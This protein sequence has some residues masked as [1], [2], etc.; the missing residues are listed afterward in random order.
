ML[1]TLSTLRTA[2]SI[3]FFPSAFFTLPAKV[4]MPPTVSTSLYLAQIGLNISMTDIA[5]QAKRRT[6]RVIKSSL[7]S[8]GR[9]KSSRC[10]IQVCPVLVVKY[11]T[12]GEAA[13]IRLVSAR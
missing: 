3:S 10:G 5:P 12:P 6:M 7:P 8:K 2:S 1:L 4:T 9:F 11:C 13:F